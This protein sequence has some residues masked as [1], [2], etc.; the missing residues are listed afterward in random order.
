MAD[1]HGGG[2]TILVDLMVKA[3]VMVLCGATCLAP[4]FSLRKSPKVE[5]SCVYGHSYAEV[6][7]GCAVIS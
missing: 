1:L 6:Q 3:S 4:V 5:V 2:C 7:D